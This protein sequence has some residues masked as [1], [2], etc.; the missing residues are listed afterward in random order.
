MTF[1]N[2]ESIDQTS[3]GSII[4]VYDHRFDRDL[5]S[6]RMWSNEGRESVK[7]KFWDAAGSMQCVRPCCVTMLHPPKKVD[8]FSFEVR[9]L[10]IEK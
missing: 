8:S 10:Q 6:M 4:K 5:H 3:Q 1:D 2:T 9:A 7:G